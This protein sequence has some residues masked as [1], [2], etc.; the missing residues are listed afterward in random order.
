MVYTQ[1][2][3][4]NYTLTLSI[5]SGGGGGCPY[6]YAW[7]GTQYIPDN[8]ILPQSESPQNQGVDVE[9]YYKLELPLVPKKGKYSILIGEFEQEHSY[10]D[11]IVLLAVD[12]DPD[13]Y[14]TVTPEGRIL[15][16]K[17]AV[18][19]ISVT[20]KNGSDVLWLLEKN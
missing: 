2:G 16:Y 12:H 14:I 5:L 4:G 1:Y 8:N 13:T 10:L 20:D 15:T 3:R 17:E 7:N 18:P 9:D 19:P 6:V 11:K